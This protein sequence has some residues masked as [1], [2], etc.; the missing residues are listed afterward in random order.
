MVISFYCYSGI[1]NP[2]ITRLHQNQWIS[3]VLSGFHRI[4]PE[5]SHAI[6]TT[7]IGL[8]FFQ[9]PPPLNRPNLCRVVKDNSMDADECLEFGTT[10]GGV[11]RRTRN[12]I[13]TQ[14]SLSYWM[15]LPDTLLSFSTNPA[16][17]WSS[18]LLPWNIL[19]SE[20]TGL[21]VTTH[22]TLDVCRMP[23]PGCKYLWSFP[24]T[25]PSIHPL[26]HSSIHPPFHPPSMLFDP[27]LAYWNKS[28][29]NSPP[30][31]PLGA[32][33]ILPEHKQKEIEKKE[34]KKESNK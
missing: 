22:K 8:S 9:P 26:I 32:Y 31:Q 20:R 21:F 17:Y 29:N 3:Q 23:F 4:S 19:L 13:L 15:I 18:L 33:E 34:R 16:L 30:L 6:T 12:Q 11:G 7:L 2:N 10:S 25:P 24:R 28:W 14:S 27:P 1:Y 5:P